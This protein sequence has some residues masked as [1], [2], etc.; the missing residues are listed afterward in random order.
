[1]ENLSPILLFVYNRPDHTEKVLDSLKRNY[2]ANDTNLFI[3]SDAAKDL[4][5][6][7]NVKLVREMIKNVDGF[8]KVTVIEAEHNKGLASS[9]IEGVSKII[10]DYNKVIVLEDDLVTS[11]YFL[12]Y[13]NES[14]VLFEKQEQIWSIS[15][16][17]PPLDIEETYN[18]EIYLAPRGCSWGWAT[19]KDR[20]L[21]TD[22]NVDN[23]I[24]FK[25]NYNDRKK[26]NKGGNDLTFMLDD[27]MSGRIN[28]W[29]I[30]WVFSQFR[31]S[32]HTIY[33]TKSLVQ[34]IGFDFSGTNSSISKKY[35]LDLYNNEIK[36][37]KDIIVKENILKSFK[38][39]Y[40]LDYLGY[41]GVITR[42]IGI[43]KQ[44]KKIRKK[45]N[46]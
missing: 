37:S 17:T 7:K 35:D 42:K 22:W 4:E 16:Y 10:R 11:P 21:S 3:F 26:F 2:L 40:D 33:P 45:F 12:K 43:Y 30:R 14:L 25:K 6:E 27:Q 24:S 13:M 28:S 36:L 32:K 31:Q 8:R 23:Y 29:A 20:W 44:V 1:M 5:N 34:N 18:K 15:G 9:I 38:S 19:W 41:L 39:F 46:K